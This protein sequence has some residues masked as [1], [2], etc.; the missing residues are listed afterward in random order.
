MSTT[1]R[2]RVPSSCPVGHASTVQRQ[3]QLTGD[4]RCFLTRTVA[5]GI[6]VRSSGS[7]TRAVRG[8]L[9]ADVYAGGGR[10]TTGVGTAPATISGSSR[11]GPGACER[12]GRILI[13]RPDHYDVCTLCFRGLCHECGATCNLCF[14]SFCHGFCQCGCQVDLLPVLPSGLGSHVGVPVYR[15]SGRCVVERER[16]RWL[17]SNF[18]PESPFE[19]DRHDG[20]ERAGAAAPRRPRQRGSGPSTTAL[21]PW[22]LGCSWDCA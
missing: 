14:G 5:A 15:F 20:R 2:E 9:L 13:T 10:R 8:P 17:N 7:R 16:R 3:Y 22:P 18:A 12:C 4:G 19:H 1:C 21:Q 6:G 11:L